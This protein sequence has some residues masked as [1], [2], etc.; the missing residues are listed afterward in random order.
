MSFAYFVVF[1]RK[2][3]LAQ[4][5]QR[6]RHGAI[7][8][9][10]LLRSKCEDKRMTTQIRDTALAFAIVLVGVASAGRSTWANGPA[11]VDATAVAIH[12]AGDR[13]IAIAA[14]AQEAAATSAAEAVVAD[15]KLEL[16]IRLLDPISRTSARR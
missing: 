13:T 12:T 15:S 11:V 8:R 4:Y 9:S 1:R 5:L 2:T 16:D 7:L 6:L 14:D 10:E 3:R